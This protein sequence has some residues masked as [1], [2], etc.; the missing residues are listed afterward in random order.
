LGSHILYALQQF[1]RQCCAGK[2]Q[3]EIALQM[4]YGAGTANAAVGESPFLT[5]AADRFEYAFV[6]QFIDPFN[7]DGTN[8]A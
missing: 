5:A 8:F 4:H 1:Q 6:D 2:V 7:L 3:P